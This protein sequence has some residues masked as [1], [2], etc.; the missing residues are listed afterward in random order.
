MTP[1]KATLLSIFMLSGI[2][3]W[4]A[5]IYTA[6]AAGGHPAVDGYGVTQSR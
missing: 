2:A 1:V 5:A 6:D 4:G 3:L